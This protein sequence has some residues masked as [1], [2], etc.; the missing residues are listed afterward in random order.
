MGRKCIGGTM[1]L[2][3]I[4]FTNKLVLV[5]PIASITSANNYAYSLTN[6]PADLNSFTANASANGVTP[7][8]YCVCGEIAIIQGSWKCKDM[9]QA[10]SGLIYYASDAVSGNLLWT[11]SSSVGIVGTQWSVQ[12]ALTDNGLQLISGN[13]NFALPKAK[14]VRLELQ[15]LCDKAFATF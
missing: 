13:M 4:R 3:Q 11:N 5:I 2:E 9:V 15:R 7:A 8:T 10:V 14:D 12:N 6:N 1:A